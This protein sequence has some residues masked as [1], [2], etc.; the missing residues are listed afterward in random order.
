MEH[1]KRGLTLIT[2]LVKVRFKS[3]NVANIAVEAVK[4]KKHTN[5]G[6][7]GDLIGGTT[8]A[9][10][11]KKRYLQSFRIAHIVFL[12]RCEAAVQKDIQLRRRHV[13][14]AKGWARWNCNYVILLDGL[15]QD[16]SASCGVA[17]ARLLAAPSGALR[18]A[19]LRSK[20][21]SAHHER[22]R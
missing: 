19:T 9:V 18:A 2:M 16:E 1:C 7:I 21:S 12:D 11:A 22:R 15:R 3:R 4:Y 13:P 20:A 10:V 14:N 8:M 17:L 5:D 6:L